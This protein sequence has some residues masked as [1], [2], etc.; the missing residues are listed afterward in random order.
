MVG[1]R[2]NRP[3]YRNDI[4]EEIR[5]FLG[6]TEIEPA[7]R[8][9]DDKFELVFNLLLNNNDNRF[10][11]QAGVGALRADDAFTIP[12]DAS[13][14]LVKKIEKRKLKLAATNCSNNFIPT[15]QPLGARSPAFARRNCSAN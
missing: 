3:E 9:D 10:T 8:E 4:A 1:I 11:I 6:L 2:T 15:L 14:L 7:E 12:A 13:A 5:L